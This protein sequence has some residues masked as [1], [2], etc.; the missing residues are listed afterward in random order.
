VGFS[1]DTGN[2]N[3]SADLRDLQQFSLLQQ[4][5]HFISE[6]APIR[7]VDER[8][9]V[10]IQLLDSIPRNSEKL[11]LE[12]LQINMAFP[13]FWYHAPRNISGDNL[14]HYGHFIID[15]LRI[16]RHRWVSISFY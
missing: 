6:S 12:L 16:K 1:D 10:V 14:H 2:D 3:T 8:P 5:Q 4:L 15:H 11:Q 13:S 9:L 7:G